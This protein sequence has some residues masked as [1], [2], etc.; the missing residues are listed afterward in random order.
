MQDS[1]K[2]SQIGNLKC[3]TTLFC[4]HQHVIILIFSD[5]VSGLLCCSVPPQAAPSLALPTT[6]SAHNS[7]GPWPTTSSSPLDVRTVEWVAASQRAM[8]C[9]ATCQSRDCSEGFCYNVWSNMVH[10]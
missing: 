10:V 5:L 3:H 1:N 2:M 4:L 7:S 8:A 6:S 9:Q